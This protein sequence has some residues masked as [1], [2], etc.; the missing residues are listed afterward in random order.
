MNHMIG[1]R[2]SS[3]PT[4]IICNRCRLELMRLGVGLVFGLCLVLS[5]TIARAEL[6]FPL[7]PVKYA[8]VQIAPHNVGIVRAITAARTC[9]NVRFDTWTVQMKK[10]AAPD[11]DFDILTCEARI[12]A[13]IHRIH[14]GDK[15]LRPPPLHPQRIAVIGDSGCRLKA[16]DALDDGFQAC[17]DP[18]DW[19]FAKVAK[20][21]AASK[22]DLI[23]HVGDYIYREQPCSGTRGCQGSPYNSPGMRWETW[24]ADF[25]KPGALMLEAAPLIFVRGDHEQCERAGAGFFRFLGPLRLRCCRD[26]TDP[27]AVNFPGLQL[28][29]MDTVQAEDTSLSPEVVHAR[30]KEDFKK[31]ANLIAGNAWL[32]SHRPI[33][34]L[35]PTTKDGSEVETLNITVQNALQEAVGALPSQVQLVLTGHIHLAEVLSFTGERPP[36]MIAG[37]GGTKLM[38]DLTKEIV[39]TALDGELISHSTI[40]STHGFIMFARRAHHAWEFILHNAVGEEVRVCR[41]ASKSAICSID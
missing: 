40:D 5:H 1:T 13:G 8:W 7:G 32:L 9:P 35:R 4:S 36:Q 28:V 14:V 33:W 6:S 27:Y 20:Q 25:F 41:L 29:V 12:P 15:H 38:P 3:Q 11:S 18:D 34:G 10:R 19:E 23:I 39:G 17:N 24:E 37:I 26:F 16:G 22:P 2:I 21:V 30:Y 31:V